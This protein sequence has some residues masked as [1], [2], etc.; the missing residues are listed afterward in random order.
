[1]LTDTLYSQHWSMSSLFLYIFSYLFYYQILD[2]GMVYA[3]N[4][5]CA[6]GRSQG[7][8]VFLVLILDG[9]SDD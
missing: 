3:Y 7:W 4:E 5:G 8:S 9:D 1:M 6:A 2:I